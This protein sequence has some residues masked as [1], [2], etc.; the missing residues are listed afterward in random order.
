MLVIVVVLFCVAWF[1]LQL[2]NVLQVTWPEINEYP[3]INIIW[4]CFDWLAMSNSCYNP[5]IYGIYN[6]SSAKI[7]YLAVR[8]L[9]NCNLISFLDSQEKF[10][11]EF[12]KRF[13]FFHKFGFGK[14]FNHPGGT[15][16]GATTL[17]DYQDK[18]MSVCGT[19]ASI[20]N[21]SSHLIKKSCCVRNENLFRNNGNGMMF[22]NSYAA[23]EEDFNYT[24]TSNPFVESNNRCYNSE[25]TEDFEFTKII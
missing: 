10:K 17:T 13:T 7:W 6:V 4:L 20:S 1:P 12:Y 9:R 25:D 21:Q 5:F 11:R 22:K 8:W 24:I 16:T 19:R 2:Y 3:H 18:T 14:R 15:Q 23:D